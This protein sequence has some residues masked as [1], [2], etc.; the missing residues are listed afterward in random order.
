MKTIDFLIQES[1]RE[2]VTRPIDI[3]VNDIDFKGFLWHAQD[4]EIDRNEVI[5][6]Y[7]D[8]SVLSNISTKEKSVFRL[9]HS[10][11]EDVD[12][13]PTVSSF[14]LLQ[15][16]RCIGLGYVSGNSPSTSPY[17]AE[18]A[19]VECVHKL[20]PSVTFIFTDS[21]QVCTELFGRLPVVKV[22][23]HGSDGYNN[24]V[25]ALAGLLNSSLLHMP[26]V[27]LK[28]LRGILSVHKNNGKYQRND[29][30][31]S[32]KELLLLGR[33]FIQKEEQ[34]RSIVGKKVPADVQEDKSQKEIQAHKEAEQK[35]AFLK[36]ASKMKERLVLE[37]LSNFFLRVQSSHE[38]EV[39]SPT[40]GLSYAGKRWSVSVQPTPYNNDVFIYTDGSTASLSD[41]TETGCAWIAIANNRIV[42]ATTLSV[43]VPDTNYGHINNVSETLAVQDALT[44]FEAEAGTRDIT[45][46]TD[47]AISIKRCERQWPSVTFC[48]VKAHDDDGYNIC[49]DILA[50]FACERDVPFTPIQLYDPEQR[51]P[52]L[53]K[54]GFTPQELNTV[55]PMNFQDI[56]DSL[57]LLK[58]INKRRKH[59]AAI[60]KRH[61]VDS[62]GN[63]F[64][65]SLKDRDILRKV[66]AL[67]SLEDRRALET[68]RFGGSPK[69]KSDDILAY[70]DMDIASFTQEERSY[71]SV[72]DAVKTCVTLSSMPPITA[73]VETPCA[74]I[75]LHT[76]FDANIA[77]RENRT[78]T[79][80]FLMYGGEFIGCLTIQTDA[81]TYGTELKQE[82]MR[83]VKKNSEY[84]FGDDA[85][86]EYA[87]QPIQPY[88][89][90][91]KS[92]KILEGKSSFVRSFQSIMPLIMDIIERTETT[93]LIVDNIMK[94]ENQSPGLLKP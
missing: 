74:V 16:D 50:H 68:A 73:S 94:E 19:A 4:S 27:T 8:G 76:P 69:P 71:A 6:A 84:L 60:I 42:Q 44:F 70:C 46:F 83:L 54:Y 20:Y 47:S 55:C 43:L 25:D 56:N 40:L 28:G 90:T 35:A 9:S 59:A 62:N 93:K 58:E 15:K 33:I 18:R 89:P 23:G 82:H 2:L 87:I 17:S 86:I 85:I 5:L 11:P 13:Y 80:A 48:K 79:V 38:V 64:L 26:R 31:R 92:R 37:M 32:E 30:F 49:V 7:T 63:Y 65:Y 3:Q 78:T 77:G 36:S 91:A 34:R 22:K 66:N 24:S 52:L 12:I 39:E 67:T 10:L 14:L 53:E 1:Q 51:K 72:N 41:H 88:Y 45:V 29:V 57:H 61:E 81:E 75:G 21:Q